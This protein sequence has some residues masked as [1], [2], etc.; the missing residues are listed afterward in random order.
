MTTPT[1]PEALAACPF[2]G[3][4]EKIVF[5]WTR[6]DAETTWWSAECHG[7]GLQILP[8]HSEAEAIAA[9][10]RRPLAAPATDEPVSATHMLAGEGD[11]RPL[12]WDESDNRCQQAATG[13]GWYTVETMRGYGLDCWRA[14]W[15]GVGSWSEDCDTIEAAKSAAQ[16]DFE[17]RIRK[18]LTAHPPAAEPVGL[19][20]AM[21]IHGL[22]WSLRE[23]VVMTLECQ[24]EQHVIEDAVK[25]VRHAADVI[26]ALAT[27]ARTD[28]AAQAGGDVDKS[29]V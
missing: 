15:S 9:W 21:P 17:S 20:E 23:H 14:T 12:A 24:A 4:T 5:P 3:E 10:N 28:D 11:V 27:P 6:I 1:K 29:Y 16:A 2:C 7:C 22:L 19:R 13:F 26:E 8:R 25:I 18:W